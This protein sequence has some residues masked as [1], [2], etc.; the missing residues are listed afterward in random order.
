MSCH[1][2]ID[3]T[4]LSKPKVP[5]I[6]ESDWLAHTSTTPNITTMT[7]LNLGTN[8]PTS[9]ISYYSLCMLWYYS[10]NN[11]LC[12]FGIRSASRY[13]RYLGRLTSNPSIIWFILS[14]LF[15]Q[16][17]D[18]RL[19]QNFHFLLL[20]LFPTLALFTSRSRH[21]SIPTQSSIRKPAILTGGVKL[22]R[23][24][25]H[26][27]HMEA[28]APS[29]R[30]GRRAGSPTPMTRLPRL[31]RYKVIDDHPKPRNRGGFASANFPAGNGDERD[32]WWKGMNT[33]SFPI[34]KRKKKTSCEGGSASL[35]R[36][37]LEVPR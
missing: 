20:P 12:T 22:P 36:G 14:H 21:I 8:N 37:D 17:N 27:H 5:N 1:V 26:N 34:T 24:C 3:N 35:G 32:G 2:V 9:R 25:T 29:G 23:S 31:S 30:S 33:R 15:H 18:S 7:P 13:R 16:S 10:S 4:Y 11:D 19:S 6:R 28:I